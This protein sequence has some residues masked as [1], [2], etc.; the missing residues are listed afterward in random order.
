MTFDLY[1][2][3]KTVYRRDCSVEFWKFCIRRRPI[4]ALM[5]PVQLFG[6]ILMKFRRTNTL[7][8]SLML[9]YIKHVDT[10]CYVQDFWIEN[11]GLINPWFEPQRR[12]LPAVVC[13]ASPE[14]LLEG[15]CEE[16]KVYKMIGT[17]VDS[18]TGKMLGKNCKHKEKIVRIAECFDLEE[19]VFENAFSDSLKSDL[20]ILSLAQNAYLVTNGRLKKI[21]VKGTK[22]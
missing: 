17:R 3:D 10:E 15:I 7:G 2:F 6:V 16:L 19:T 14:F 11:R 13:S 12:R 20:P 21:D 9:S 4:L 1:D 18:E 8:K 5:S 22:E